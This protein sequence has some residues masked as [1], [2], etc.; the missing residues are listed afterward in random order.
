MLMLQKSIAEAMRVMCYTAGADTDRAEHLSDTEAREFFHDRVALMV[1]IVKAWCTELCQEVASI[2]VQIHGGMG[3][4]E[5]T[6]AAPIYRDARITTIY[7]GTTG[8]QAQ[9]LAGRKIIRD[10]GKAAYR[11]C[12]DIQ[13]TIKALTDAG[14]S[15]QARQLNAGL[16]AMKSSVDWLLANY[17][18]DQFAPNAVCYN[19][20]MAC[21]TVVAAWGMA[22]TI[23]AAK[24]R[25]DAGD[26]DTTYLNAKLT[27]AGFFLDDVL[28]RA[29]A[30]AE[31][32]RAGSAHI[33]GLSD[34]Q[35]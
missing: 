10:R 5:E 35:F 15:T 6:G 24:A 3:Y 22:R 33:M 12:D 34:E 13:V 21:G 1:P 23:L 18:D 32:V 30:F 7:E 19:L 11:L 25:L 29:G 4:V 14:M 16:D 2:G 28:P 20:L 8:I 26:P 9:D 17:A 27:T 31:S